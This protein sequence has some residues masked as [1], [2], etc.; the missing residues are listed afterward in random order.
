MRERGADGF[1]LFNIP[2]LPEDVRSFVY[3]GLV[4]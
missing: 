2:Y 1:Y 4:Q 3:R